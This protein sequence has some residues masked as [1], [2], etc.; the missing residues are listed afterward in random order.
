M[1]G[2][3]RLERFTLKIPVKVEV[4]KSGKKQI[5]NLV[6]NNISADGAYFHM[7]NPLSENTTVQLSLTISSDRLKKLTGSKSLIKLK[8]TVIRSEPTGIAVRFAERY[9]VVRLVHC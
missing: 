5:F 8:G 1:E 9:Q 4:L 7:L 3:R 6:T 2:R